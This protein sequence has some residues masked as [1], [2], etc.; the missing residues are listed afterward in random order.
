MDAMMLNWIAIGLLVIGW[1]V[2]HF[3][4]NHLGLLMQAAG[5][6]LMGYIG[7]LFHRM[8]NFDHPWLAWVM[9]IVGPLACL[10][11]LLNWWKLRK[12]E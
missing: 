3:M 4:K 6:G 11:T 2:M 1:L 10:L 8:D 5:V 7:C 9:M 12:G